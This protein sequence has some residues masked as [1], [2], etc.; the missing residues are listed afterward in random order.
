MRMFAQDVAFHRRMRVEGVPDRS[1]P[2]PGRQHARMC[3]SATGHTAKAFLGEA[4]ERLDIRVAQVDGGLEFMAESE[5]DCKKRGLELLVLPPRSP[6]SSNAP[7]ARCASSVGACT[8]TTS[9]APD[10]RR[11]GPLPRLLQQ[12][13]R[14]PLPRHGNAG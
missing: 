10:E 7:T 9:P 8:G 14:A 13:A 5:D 1:V 4:A 11:L 2:S 6:A 3:S 12:P